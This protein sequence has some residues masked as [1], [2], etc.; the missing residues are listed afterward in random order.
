MK[1]AATIILVLSAW[2]ALSLANPV[3]VP[4]VE[5]TAGLYQG[6]IDLTPEQEAEIFGTDDLGRTG[7]RDT[8]RRWPNK[9]VFY[10]FQDQ[11]A[12]QRVA[13]RLALDEIEYYSCIEF[14]E[15]TTQTNFINIESVDVDGCS[16]AVGMTGGKQVIK[17]ISSPPGTGCFIRGK[18]QHEFMHA[19]GFWHLHSAPT[20]SDFI[21][22]NWA[23][24]EEGRENAFEKR[25]TGEAS[26]YG[27]AYNYNSVMHYAKDAFSKNGLNTITPLDPTKIDIIGQRDYL[28]IQDMNR[29]NN[30]YDC[31]R[32]VR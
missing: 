23:N 5:E 9:R 16:S 7:I 27:V 11:T 21:Q 6:D 17:L 26:L 30:L 3:R 4:D 1:P 14:I 25:T 24:I 22:I 29:L 32:F 12:E 15:R 13:I 2:A 8:T 10:R 18:I 28:P 20:R 19:L 31:P